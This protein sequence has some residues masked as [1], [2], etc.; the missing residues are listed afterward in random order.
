MAKTKIETP[1]K[2]FTGTVA[3][4]TFADGEG[5]TDDPTALAYF[6][7]HG[8]KVGG[9]QSEKPQGTPETT[10]ETPAVETKPKPAKKAA[11]RKRA[12]KKAA[13]KPSSDEK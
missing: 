12:A 13:T 8:Y 10:P 3:G 9:K 5:E 7:R 2:D 11:P 1:V 6:K 4:V